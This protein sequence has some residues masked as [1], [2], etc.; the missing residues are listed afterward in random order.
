M[1]CEQDFSIRLRDLQRVPGG[2][3]AVGAHVGENPLRRATVVSA[4]GQQASGSALDLFGL[5]IASK[6]RV[7]THTVPVLL[8]NDPADIRLTAYEADEKT[9][10]WT[11]TLR[12]E[13]PASL[14]RGPVSSRFQKAG[15]GPQGWQK[16]TMPKGALDTAEEMVYETDAQD[17]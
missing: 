12:C 8:H 1:N 16:L 6:S 5:K 15:D 17:T 13:L 4:E 14:P 2:L 9:V 11:A 7:G 3:L 10:K